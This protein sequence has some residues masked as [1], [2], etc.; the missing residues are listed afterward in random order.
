MPILKRWFTTNRHFF[1]LGGLLSI[2]AAVCFVCAG[3]LALSR[4][5]FVH[6]AARAEGTVVGYQET[7][8]EDGTAYVPVFRFKDEAGAEHE[9]ASKV[10]ANSRVY[11]IGQAVGVFYDPV[12]PQNAEVDDFFALWGRA[13]ILA[14]LGGL[15]FLPGG[16]LLFIGVFF[17]R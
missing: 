1:I 16:A 5:R 4:V 11:R 9:V 6:G 14:V 7:P 17:R 8:S 15:L 12:A 13:S 2:P 3:W 10:V